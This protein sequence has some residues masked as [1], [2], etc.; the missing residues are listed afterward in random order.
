MS[1]HPEYAEINLND[2]T[3]LVVDDEPEI[4]EVM[5]DC[6]SSITK[7]IKTAKNGQEALALIKMGGIDAIV[8]DVKMPLM[9]GLQ[10]LAEIRSL[11]LLTPFVIVT[12][13]TEKQTLV[14]AI[15][16]DATDFVDKPFE[17]SAVVQIVSRALSLGLLQKI[18]E[19]QID[20]IYNS[21][22]LPADEIVKSKKYQKI[23]ARLR[24]EMEV[25][26]KK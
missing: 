20:Q 13:F 1:A 26:K 22:S 9:T 24:I 17:P 7:K 11:G 19:K 16:L 5:V 2:G 10:L 18:A 6:L 25:L 14:E 21:S 4:L 8:S 23:M 12:G 3:L 15:R